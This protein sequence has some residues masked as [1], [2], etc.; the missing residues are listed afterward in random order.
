MKKLITLATAVAI[1]ASFAL[2]KEV[3]IGLV[4]PMSGPIGAFG[5]YADKGLEL[6]N[7]MVP[8]LENGDAIK[9]VLVDNKSDKIESANGMQRLISRE[10]V[11]AVIGALTSTNT[12][13]IT[14]L[15]DDNKIPMVAPVATN[16]LVTKNRSFVSRACFNDSFQGVVAANYLYKDL[17]MKSAAI[18]VDSKS[19]YSIGLSNAF[20]KAYT[21]LG[22]K[23]LRKA[24]VTA[25]DSDFKGILSNLKALDPQVVYIPLYSKEAVLII[26]QAAQLGFTPKFMGSDGLA[27]DQIFFDVGKSAING[28]SNT[29]LFSPDAP[30]TT[31]TS[32][33]FFDAYKKKY[34]E[35][36]HPFAALSADAYLMIVEGMN[37]C[38]G[39]DDKV[40]VNKE[41]RSLKN[42]QAATGVISIDEN[43]DA[44]RS[45]VVNTVKDGALVFT[46]TVNP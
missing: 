41:I 26:T 18:I 37:Q 40:C 36:V 44:I 22:G 29:D 28:T 4:M 5:Q 8:T 34:G 21:A 42:F 13:A 23:I 39:A 33:A 9:L 43:G 35:K 46:K 24:I 20:K 7:E 14:R 27:A 17:G 3:K 15:A 25:G 1:L 45:A 6:I 32:Q 30:A 31:A 2:A 38:G 12:M 11:S 10:N 19:D 16:V